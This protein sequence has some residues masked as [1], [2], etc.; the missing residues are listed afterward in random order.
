MVC[1]MRLWDVS[2]VCVCVCIVG[3]WDVSCVCIVRLWYISGVFS[4]VI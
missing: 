2:C 1:R 4:G 3:L